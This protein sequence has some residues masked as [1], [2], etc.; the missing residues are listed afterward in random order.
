MAAVFP[1]FRNPLTAASRVPLRPFL[2]FHDDLLRRLF[3]GNV[4]HY[5]ELGEQSAQW[6]FQEGPY[7]A[8][9]AKRDVAQF[10]QALPAL[11]R[12]YFP[13]AKSRCEARLVDGDVEYEVFDLPD[14]HP[15]FE[16]LIA[17]Y[18]K[19]ALNLMYIN[20]V[21]ALRVRGGSGRGYKYVFRAGVADD[22]SEASPSSRAPRSARAALS[23]REVE[24]LRLITR[25]K[26]DKE[27]ATILSISSRTVQTHAR[28]IYDK[29]GVWNRAGAATW[30]AEQNGAP[31]WQAQDN[32]VRPL[33]ELRTRLC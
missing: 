10:V 33:T 20:P 27:I 30:L 29:I 6:A 9:I 8:L 11:W 18:H 5:V 28:H 25:G 2:A 23:S 13:E 12:A 1:C 22:W 4:T 26:T 31:A 17:G 32:Q 19:A 16:Y 3:D 21:G 14:Y 15:Y 7:Q 24:V